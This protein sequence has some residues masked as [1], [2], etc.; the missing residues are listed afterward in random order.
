VAD[1]DRNPTGADVV[2]DSLVHQGVRHIFGIPGAK[3]DGVFDV[4]VDRGPQLVVCRHEQN[5]AFMA[6]AVGRL[7]GRPGVCL[8]TSGPGAS[9]LVT[10]LL[11]AT[12]EGDP[13]VALIG[14]VPR[15]HAL[16]RTHQSVDTTALFSS[17]AKYSVEVEHVDNV[18]EAM[19]TAFQRAMTPPMGAAVVA[20]PYDVMAA[21]TSVPVIGRVEAPRAGAAPP[22]AVLEAAAR[23]GRARCPVL[24]LGGR[25]GAPGV[26]EALHGL[27]ATGDL[28]VVETFQSAGA[29]TRPLLDHFCGRVG[30]FRNQPGDL[31]LGE[32]D[33]VIAV[34][35][36]PVEYD[37]E[38]W[39]PGRGV[40][41]VHIDDLPASLDAHYQPE[42]Q[43]I[44]GVSATI[45]AL[46]AHAADWRS[47]AAAKETVAKLR[48]SLDEPP[49]QASS[50]AVVHPTQIVATLRDLLP[51]ETVVAC[52]IGSNY[53]WMARHF[54][55]F[56][57]RRL[58]F[59][60][61]QQTL[62]VALPWA[63]AASLVEPGRK[64][65]SVSG[66]GGFGF[67]AY[68][69]TTAV[70]LRSEIVHLVWCDG[71]YDMVA[72]QQKLKYGRASGT[73]LGPVD[74]VAF[75]RSFGATGL[76]VTTTDDLRPVL[77]QALAT[78]GPVIVEIPVDYSHNARLF[79]EVHDDILD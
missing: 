70:G 39:N 19:A 46:T 22:D 2:V 20:L 66:D 12:T 18:G 21:T 76:R 57:P 54:R 37:P 73:G 77:E 51:D 38:L 14:T 59:S 9:N 75:A 1:A 3:V 13:V 48:A 28:P 11:T 50:A 17:F 78:P 58:L 68:E 64:V 40:A 45:A 41:I 29:V 72:S 26:V 27:L 7:T 5:A 8:V 53:V 15:A 69:L 55:T 47:D 60:N 24:L 65:V 79:S 74:F 6:G 4:L 63:I 23:I 62:G 25:A 44:G 10:G 35:Y 16:K 31:V 52:D 71:T 56:E 43:L 61:G 67:S 33:L 49:M 36:D 30:L 42:I 34:G 32:A